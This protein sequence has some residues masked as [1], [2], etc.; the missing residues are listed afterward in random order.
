MLFIC[1][2]DSFAAAGKNNVTATNG[3]TGDEVNK[4]EKFYLDYLSIT[5]TAITIVQE[6]KRGIQHT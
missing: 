3:L 4:D 6:F 2:N 1:C 5:N